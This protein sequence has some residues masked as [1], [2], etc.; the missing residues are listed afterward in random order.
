MSRLFIASFADEILRNQV[1]SIKQSLSSKELRWTQED[2][3]HLTWLFLGEQD[4]ECL[5]KIKTLMNEWRQDENKAA[6]LKK[7]SISLDRVEYWPTKRSPRL[8]V[9]AAS[10]TP[11]TALELS[12]LIN[13]ELSQFL[14]KPTRKFRP[15]IT[16]FRIRTKREKPR[17]P[18]LKVP[19][20]L[21][22]NSL[23]LVES[24]LSSGRAL[25][26]VRYSIEL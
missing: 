11:D 14:E 1:E 23:D 21:M 3:L 2:N 13:S 18:D 12:T 19:A 26:K 10:Q 7:T 22:V 8:G 17:L 6:M 20:E 16:I 25:Y 4:R 24:D 5:E 9:L 15:H